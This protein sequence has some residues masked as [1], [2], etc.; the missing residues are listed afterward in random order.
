MADKSLK[1]WQDAIR[2]LSE[3]EESNRRIVSNF[4]RMA[5]TTD[6]RAALWERES[7]KLSHLDRELSDY[8]AK[9]AEDMRRDARE[10]RRM[11]EEL[12]K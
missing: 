2:E 7:K 3:E 12:S 6:Y 10:Y 8:Y 4:R 5:N 9:I 1:G 11:A